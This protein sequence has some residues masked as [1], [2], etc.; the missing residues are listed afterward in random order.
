MK[1]EVV[2]R[3]DEVRI[4]LFILIPHCKHCRDTV[5]EQIMKFGY[6]ERVDIGFPNPEGSP[7]SLVYKKGKYPNVD[8][9]AL[10]KEVKARLD[11]L[12]YRVM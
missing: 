9:W 1:S 3:G 7:V 6:W 10:A 12:G 4:V 11:A 2:E 8:Y 5:E